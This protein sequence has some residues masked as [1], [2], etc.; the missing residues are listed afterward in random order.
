[1]E[2]DNEIFGEERPWSKR[3][4]DLIIVPPMSGA[5]R[6]LQLTEVHKR[7]GVH[8]KP[9]QHKPSDIQW[10]IEYQ[11]DGDEYL[12]TSPY[13]FVLLLAHTT[14]A[15][16]PVVVQ[17]PFNMLE[18]R[19]KFHQATIDGFELRGKTITRY[20]E[21]IFSETLE[22]IRRYKLGH[23]T[24]PD[25]ESTVRHLVGRHLIPE[26]L[27]SPF[28]R[29][30]FKHPSTFLLN[31]NFGGTNLEDEGTEYFESE[32]GPPFPCQR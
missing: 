28:P 5:W 7:L 32:S 13:G 23:R 17:T 25:I 31:P 26:T 22:F 18:E 29:H 9:M 4:R 6:I 11:L 8:Y 19:V 15:W 1:M 2:Q 12:L 10:L 27:S 21:W 14:L 3:I 16:R 24:M 30:L 20:T